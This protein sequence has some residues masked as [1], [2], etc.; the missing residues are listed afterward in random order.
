VRSVTSRLLTPL[1][2]AEAPLEAETSFGLAPQPRSAP[3]IA[4]AIA[5][6]KISRWRCAIWTW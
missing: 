6:G 1:L 2:E 4:Q 3:L 5:T